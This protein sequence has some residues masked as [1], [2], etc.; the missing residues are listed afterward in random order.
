MRLNSPFLTLKFGLPN[1]TSNPV[2]FFF[3]FFFPSLFLVFIFFCL[4]NEKIRES[5]RKTLNK[6]SKSCYCFFFVCN[7]SPV[8]V[9]A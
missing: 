8:D 2:A 3:F 7:V 6:S 9:R 1:L 4:V 5:D